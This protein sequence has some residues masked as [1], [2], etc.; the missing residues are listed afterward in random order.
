MDQKFNTKDRM[1]FF[2]IKPS[3]SL[4]QNFLND[5]SVVQEIVYSANLT[6]EDIVVEVGPGLGV[7]TDLL[8]EQAGLVIAVEIGAGGTLGGRGDLLDR[9]VDAVG[10]VNADDLDLDLLSLL[11]MLRDLA[12]I[13]ISDLRDVHQTGATLRQR[14]ERAKLSDTRNFSVQDRSNTKLHTDL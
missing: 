5:I 8:A 11:Q 7:M 10:L 13:G 12:D 14:H 3:K 2:G 6:E 1:N 9:Q 4:G